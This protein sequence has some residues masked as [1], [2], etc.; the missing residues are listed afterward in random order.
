MTLTNF[1]YN[2]V[3][4]DS[5]G[6]GEQYHHSAW[7]DGVAD[8]G[9]ST[10]NSAPLQARRD[11]AQPQRGHKNTCTRRRATVGRSRNNGERVARVVRSSHTPLVARMHR[12]WRGVRITRC[13]AT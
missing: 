9:I 3:V 7:Y 12:A 10:R 11:S 6:G 2:I 1:V 4:Y 13:A 8:I 5:T